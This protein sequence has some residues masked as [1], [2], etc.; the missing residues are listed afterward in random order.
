MEIRQSPPEGGTR[1]LLHSLDGAEDI[2]GGEPPPG[3]Q[4]LM[5]RAAASTVFPGGAGGM[6]L[7]TV[8]AML[9]PSA[10]AATSAASRIGQIHTP[11]RRQYWR[12]EPAAYMQRRRPQ[13]LR[14]LRLFGVGSGS[15][16]AQ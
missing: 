3:P 9:P 2:G 7:S 12:R 14:Q 8:A 13:Q 15:A 16:A 11:I 10:V 5:G 1:P 6:P 4:P